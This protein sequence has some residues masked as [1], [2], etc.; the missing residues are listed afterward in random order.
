MAIPIG[1]GNLKGAAGGL[2]E[3]DR[4]SGT[5]RDLLNPASREVGIGLSAGRYATEPG[6]PTVLVVDFGARQQ[7]LFATSLG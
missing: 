5:P 7:R 6:T 2:R 3:L 4:E 1:R